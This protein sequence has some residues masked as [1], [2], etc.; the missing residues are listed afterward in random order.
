MRRHAPLSLLPLCGLI[1]L[2]LALTFAPPARPSVGS[3]QQGIAADRAREQN[4]QLA[5]GSAS[6]LIARVDGQLSILSGRVS[7]IE[8]QLAEQR[9]RVTELA[10][11]LVIER[12]LAP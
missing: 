1:A 3:L 2:L 9:S 10:A 12:R 7:A 6:A 5:A 11:D 4:L 8:A